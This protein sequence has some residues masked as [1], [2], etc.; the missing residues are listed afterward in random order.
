MGYPGAP[1]CVLQGYVTIHQLVKIHRF[2]ERKGA[3]TQPTILQFV[4]KSDERF[5]GR[6]DAHVCSLSEPYKLKTAMKCHVISNRVATIEKN[7]SGNNKC[8]QGCRTTESCIHC[9]WMCQ[10][11]RYTLEDTEY[12]EIKLTIYYDL[13]ISI[14]EKLENMHLMTWLRMFIA[15]LLVV[16]NP[17]LN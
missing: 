16:V 2:R 9:W 14:L 12:Y 6:R 7:N 5:N 8:W 17:K 3:K 11:C 15:T 4:D 1:H 10:L 13:S